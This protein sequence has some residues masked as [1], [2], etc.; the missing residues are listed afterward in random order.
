MF[1]LSAY[2]TFL[3]AC[4]AVV[5]VPGPTVTVIIANSLRYG[6]RAGLANVAGTQAGLAVM[7]AVL[8]AGLQVVVQALGTVFEVVK[9]IGAAYLVYLGLKLLLS[10]SSLSTAGA[11]AAI[12]AATAARTEPFS[13]RRYFWQGV[14]VIWANPKALLFFG[15][16]I[17]Q[18]V[19][20]EGP[21]VAQ[22]LLLG[23]TFMAVATCLDSGYAL[24]SGRAGGWLTR[25]RVRVLEVCSGCFLIGGG[26]W[27]ALTRR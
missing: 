10:R 12:E 5:I 4:V 22:T 16:F 1:E 7:L 8:A 19:R 25:Q 20:P 26:V 18:F 6:A 15:A 17:P 23:L 11:D 13:W 3:L 2:L 27:L 24:L 21:V 9:L 14:L